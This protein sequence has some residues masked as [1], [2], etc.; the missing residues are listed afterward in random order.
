MKTLKYFAIRLPQTPLLC[1]GLSSMSRL[2]SIDSSPVTDVERGPCH[3]HFARFTYRI[4][5]SGNP[6]T[7]HIQVKSFNNLTHEPTGR[8]I[9]EPTT[10]EPI[11]STPFMPADAIYILADPA[12]LDLDAI[13][14]IQEIGPTNQAP[15]GIPLAAFVGSC[16]SVYPSTGS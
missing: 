13:P 6:T 4:Y 2:G 14:V 5:Y 15:N 11:H 7:D 3:I 16:C 10:R 1:E 12:T 9:V 8:K